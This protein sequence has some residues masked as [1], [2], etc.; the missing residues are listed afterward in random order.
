MANIFDQAPV[1]QVAQPTQAV[2]PTATS[3]ANGVIAQSSNPPAPAQPA[4][5]LSKKRSFKLP[6]NRIVG[7]AVIVLLALRTFGVALPTDTWFQSIG[8]WIVNASGNSLTTLGY[9]FIFEMI[10]AVLVGGF[11]GRRSK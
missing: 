1:Q 9:F 11:L 6:L 4:A 2:P 10:A 3:V 8:K 5:Q 7:F